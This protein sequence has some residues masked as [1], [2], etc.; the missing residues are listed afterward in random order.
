MWARAL[1][2]ADAEAWR[3]GPGAKAVYRY[4]AE[5]GQ[6]VCTSSR[7]FLTPGAAGAC[8]PTEPPPWWA[9]RLMAFQPLPILTG[10]TWGEVHCYGP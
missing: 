8:P 4:N 10:E 3:A 1:Q 9:F 5:T 2:T 7:S 6:A